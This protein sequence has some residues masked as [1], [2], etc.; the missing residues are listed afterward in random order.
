MGYNTTLIV[1]NDALHEI[2]ED[3]EFGKKVAQATRKASMLREGDR[4]I[5]IRSGCHVNAATVV[6]THHADQVKLIAVGGNCGQD[7]GYHGGYRSD[8]EDLLR[9]LADDLGYRIV[10]KSKPK[11]GE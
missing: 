6:E 5:D 10:K 2:E 8:K 1:L 11:S 7:L 3:P 9:S 4:G